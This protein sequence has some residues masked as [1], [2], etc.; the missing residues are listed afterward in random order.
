MRI[1]NQ[2]L[3]ASACARRLELLGG[4]RLRLSLTFTASLWHS[5]R[6]PSLLVLVTVNPF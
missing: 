2:Q 1:A 6:L 3:S 4:H 5:L